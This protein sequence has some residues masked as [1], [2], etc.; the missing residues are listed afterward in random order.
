MGRLA[1]GVSVVTYSWGWVQ[2]FVGVGV[3]VG[4]RKEVFSVFQFRKKHSYNKH[5]YELSVVLCWGYKENG[6]KSLSAASKI[7]FV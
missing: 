5:D 2:I 4:V 1:I 3:G 6:L 7:A